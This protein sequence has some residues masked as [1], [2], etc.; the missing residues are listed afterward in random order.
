MRLLFL[1]TG[2]SVALAGCQCVTA[3]PDVKYRCVDQTDCVDDERCVDLL[4]EPRGATTDAGTGD[5]G[6]NGDAGLDAGAPDAGPDAGEV[7]AG[8]EAGGER[9]CAD[10]LDN[11]ADGAF[12]CADPDCD[13]ITCR[14]RGSEPCNVKELCENLACPADVPALGVSCDDGN[15]C[16]SNDVCLNGGVCIGTKGELLVTC[17]TDQITIIQKNACPPP[18]STCGGMTPDQAPLA[19]AVPDAGLQAFYIYSPKV[20]PQLTCFQPDGGFSNI[21]SCGDWTIGSTASTTC[22]INVLYFPVLTSPFDGGVPVYQYA[23]PTTPGHSFGESSAPPVG[24][25]LEPSTP[26]FYACPF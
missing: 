10:R 7:D 2:L 12:D 5:A 22:G 26:L 15:P 13:G 4:C 24:S 1:L 14:P 17:S 8:V 20:D 9:S 23:N 18:A 21:D 25:R 11:D 3:P 6:G 16:T 19:R